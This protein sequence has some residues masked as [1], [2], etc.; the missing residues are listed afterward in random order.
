MFIDVERKCSGRCF[1]EAKFIWNELSDSR[2]GI[3][4]CSV[5][6]KKVSQ[7]K[8]LGDWHL[9]TTLLN[10]LCWRKLRKPKS[11]ILPWEIIEKRHKKRSCMIK[12][13]TRMSINI[14][15]Y[16]IYAWGWGHKKE[17]TWRDTSN[18]VYRSS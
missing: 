10:R 16:D 7:N 1:S 6:T 12:Y 13:W 5:C 14:L 17:N 3:D 18:K 8:L 2:Y 11:K 4:R 9:E 15:K